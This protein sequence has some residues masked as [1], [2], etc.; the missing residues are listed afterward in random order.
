[1]LK[2]VCRGANI[3]TIS[4]LLTPCLSVVGMTFL[5]LLLLPL[6]NFFDPV[7][8]RKNFCPSNF[9]GACYRL[10]EKGIFCSMKISL[11]VFWI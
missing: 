2:K 3:L 5:L 7:V 11:F 1:M 9:L 10:N 4:L 6:W 8:V